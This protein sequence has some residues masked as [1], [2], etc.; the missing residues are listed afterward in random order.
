MNKSLECESVVMSVIS[1]A[2]EVQHMRS[3]I[4]LLTL[5][6]LNGGCSK[7]SQSN[8]TVTNSIGMQLV[9]I[10]KGTFVMGSPESEKGRRQDEAQHEVT[11]TKD[12]YLG[13]FEVTQAQY[14][15][16][17]G[18]N[19]S[20]FQAPANVERTR[21][22][23]V[24]DT[25][26]HPVE[27]VSFESA[28][29]FCQRLTELPEEK[30]AGRV[31]RLPTEAEWEYACRAGNN[32]SFSGAVYADV[33]VDSIFADDAD[34]LDYLDMGC[35]TVSIQRFTTKPNAWGLQSMHGH[36]AEWCSDWYGK[37][38]SEPVIDPS[39]P[40]DGPHHV[41]RGGCFWDY[42][43]DCRSACRNSPIS[44]VGVVGFRV[45]LISSDVPSVPLKSED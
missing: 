41:M 39:G 2:T 15:K 7:S 40:P 9:R 13:R 16:V 26:K 8:K 36:V 17:V 5:L 34:V 14:K 38:P 1:D 6:V 21:R 10:P 23:G 4:A 30:K 24:I 18:T 32:T 37:Y 31:Y 11:I 44:S 20:Y 19:P 42:R 3:L 28:V 12:F 43:E 25:S 27:K 33:T 29:M 35:S 22:G 45:V